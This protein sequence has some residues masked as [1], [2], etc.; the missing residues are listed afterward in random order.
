MS[1]TSFAR[2]LIARALDPRAPHAIPPSGPIEVKRRRVRG[3][4]NRLPAGW[5]AAT[6]VLAGRLGMHRCALAASRCAVQLGPD[7]AA[8]WSALSL[9]AANRGPIG[10]I[11]HPELG[12]VRSNLGDAECALAAARAATACSEARSSDWTNLTTQTMRFGDIDAARDA[13]E[14]AVAEFP[15]CAD[16][17]FLRARVEALDAARRGSFTD[18]NFALH[19]YHAST[20]LRADPNHDN[21]RYH[22]I[23]VALRNADWETAA[24]AARSV[25]PATP[26]TQLL[27]QTARLTADQALAVVDECRTATVANDLRLVGHWRLIADGHHHAAF[28]VKDQYAESILSQLAGRRDHHAVV[29]QIRALACLG[30]LDE[31][32]RMATSRLSDPHGATTRA[33]LRQFQLDLAIMDGRLEPGFFQPPDVDGLADRHYRSI[34]EGSRVAVVGPTSQPGDEEAIGRAEI[35][36]RARALDRFLGKPTGSYF[37]DVAAVALAEPISVA[38]NSDLDIAVTRPSSIGLI[39]SKLAEHPRCRRSH[40]LAVLLEATPYAIPRIVYDVLRFR[41]ASVTVF[42]TAF[43]VEGRVYDAAERHHVGLREDLPGYGHDL[44]SDHRLMKALLSADLIAAG[45]GTRKII[46]MGTSDY[47]RRLDVA[48]SP[49]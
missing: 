34:I 24:D 7:C 17:W 30:R 18:A 23:R 6:S 12:V 4:A 19:R 42:S 25:Q 5:L 22:L 31:A 38:L 21:A 49:A 13:A 1:T 14:E 46:S 20:A 37:A 3:V 45:D 11:F 48:G 41:P 33:T 27:T 15:E 43:F 47:L 2:W 29:R 32:N 40:E 35:V 10:D 26:L 44:R 36:L 39:P 28:A 9:A 16:A 8:A